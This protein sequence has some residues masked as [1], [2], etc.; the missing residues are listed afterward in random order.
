M[1]YTYTA[2]PFSPQ[3]DFE[4]FREHVR[5]EWESRTLDD[6][7]AHRA[8]LGPRIEQLRG[9]VNRSQSQDAEFEDVTGASVVMD[10]LISEKTLAKRSAAIE[11]VRQ[12]AMDPANC[13][14]PNPGPAGPG[15]PALV[16]GLGD[17]RESA[18]E[19]VQPQR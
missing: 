13:E 16:K 18:A 5:G 2:A 4:K 12:A 8:D 11:R 14:G 15:A 17:R 1:T 7:L 10:E 3:T 19:I 9:Y 6:C